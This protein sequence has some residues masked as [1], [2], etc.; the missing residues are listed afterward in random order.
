MAHNLLQHFL[1]A[2]TLSTDNVNWTRCFINTKYSREERILPCQYY[3]MVVLHWHQEKKLNE[4]LTRMLYT[5]LNKSWKQHTTKQHTT[6]QQLCGHL[7]P[8]HKPVRWARHTG[9]R[10]T[11]KRFSDRLL[12]INILVLADK[13]NKKTPKKL[14][15]ISSVQIL[16]AI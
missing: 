11:H 1:F 10:W 7:P 9:E 13:K 14:T 4:N 6:K 3:T 2:S 5:V 16:V 12:H 8:S 15:F